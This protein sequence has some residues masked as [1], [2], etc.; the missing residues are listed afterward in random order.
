[1]PG[2]TSAKAPQMTPSWDLVRPSVNLLL[3]NSEAVITI[4]LLPT[5]AMVLGSMLTLTDYRTG[6]IVTSIGGLWRFINV[7]VSIYLQASAASGK[8]PSISEC[9]RRGLSYWPKVI[10][11]EI[12]FF[13]M[14]LIGLILLVVP[15]LIIIRRYYLTPFYIV[16]QNLS[17]KK[18]MRLAERQTKPVAGYVWGVIGVMLAFAL[19]ASII[20]NIRIV[21]VILAAFIS[22]IYLFGPALRWREISK[23]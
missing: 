11:F 5:L 12:V 8:N 16:K 21:G 9:Y 10:G 23:K 3:K 22:L 1:M 6:L 15:G 20:A 2:K 7:P 17:I 18:A 19:L 4:V 13:F 14:T